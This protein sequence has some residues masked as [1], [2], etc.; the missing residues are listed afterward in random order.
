MAIALFKTHGDRTNS[1]P[2]AIALFKTH[3]DRVAYRRYRSF[4]FCKINRPFN[5][6]L[7]LIPSQYIA[8]LG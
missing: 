3:G 4:M 5:R 8:F 1:K 6:S 2:M 7:S